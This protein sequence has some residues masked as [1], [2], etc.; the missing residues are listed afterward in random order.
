MSIA[1]KKALRIMKRYS[2]SLPGLRFAPTD[3]GGAALA[4]ALALFVPSFPEN[5]TRAAAVQ[6]TPWS[7]DMISSEAFE[8]HAAIDPRTGDFWFVRS[9]TDFTGWRLMVSRCAGSVALSPAAPE[10]AGEGLEADPA[11]S[12]D[13]R[14]LYFISTRAAG[15][16][17]GRDLD[18]WRIDR[19]DGL[20]WSAPERL[21]EPVNSIEAEWFP[22][23]GADGWLYFGSNRPGGQ[24]KNDI[25]RARQDDAGGW[26]IENAGPQ[27]NS[28]GDEYE[29]L[30]SPDGQTMIVEAS[31][32]YFISTQR[33]GVWARRE[34]LGP[35]INA[36][37]SEIGALFSPSGMSIL[38]ARDTGKP[39]SGEFFLWR[40]GGVEDWPQICGP[41][42]SGSGE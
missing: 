31:E 15:S 41:V 21:P 28:P 38:F 2:E 42:E 19:G 1:H 25:W 10:F 17:K 24:G 40:L 11:F 12:P 30:P 14:Y 26:V 18:I 32:G 22:R 6:I 27:I 3:L 9:N 20:R 13:G 33:D 35:E 37:G 7:A 39:M 16:L 23:Q 4:S 8:S 5:P 34:K 36:N 29:A